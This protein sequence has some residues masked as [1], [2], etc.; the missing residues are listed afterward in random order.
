MSFLGC[1]KTGRHI[2]L[3]PEEI[4]FSRRLH[5]SADTDQDGYVEVQ[6]IY[7]HMVADG[8]DATTSSRDSQEL[9]SMFD[10]NRDNKLS[11]VEFHDYTA[12]AISAYD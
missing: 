1:E 4:E 2:T 12:L 3:R 7:N 9:V 10:D 6:E 5:D 8:F 11:L